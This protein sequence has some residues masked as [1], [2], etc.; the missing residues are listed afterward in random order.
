MSTTISSTNLYSAGANASDALSRLPQ[1]TLGQDD[2][3]KLL[4]VQMTS[5]DPLEPLKE[6]DFIAQ[7]AQFSTLQQTQNMT[8]DLAA[9]HTDQQ[10][11]QANALLGRVVQL[12]QGTGSP[13]SGTVSAVQ[14]QD[15]VPRIVVNDQTYDLS[16]VL[17]VAASP[18]TQE[19]QP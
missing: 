12:Q 18:T 14:I 3:L 9:L 13:V 10:L 16:A 19:T 2:F 1:K 4:T 7:L 15:G 17:A 8:T 6:T 5:Q 11:L